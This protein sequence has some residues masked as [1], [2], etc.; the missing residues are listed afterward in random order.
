MMSQCQLQPLA[1]QL[2]ANDAGSILATRLYSLYI[3]FEFIFFYYRMNL[4]WL[5]NL[6]I[7]HFN[8]LI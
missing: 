4:D 8:F 2:Q 5:M 3:L 7:M 1:F 6:S